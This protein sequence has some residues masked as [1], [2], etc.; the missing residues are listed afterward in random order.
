MSIF[1]RKNR[2]AELARCLKVLEVKPGDVL[3][4]ETPRAIPRDV[5]RRLQ[6]QIRESV[7]NTK[8]V[9]LEC[10]LTARA[11]VRPNEDP[12]PA[13]QARLF[14]LPPAQEQRLLDLD[15]AREERRSRRV[16]PPG[17]PP[18]PIAGQERIARPSP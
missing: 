2:H 15:S 11:I 14:P 3:L 16:D 12:P 4:V 5:Y 7:P 1:R 9:V 6:A 17:P 8:L 10:G 13:L 18:A